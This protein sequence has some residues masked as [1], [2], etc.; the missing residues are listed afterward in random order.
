MPHQDRK[1]ERIIVNHRVLKQAIDKLLKAKA[2][3]RIGIRSG[4]KWTP[5]TLVVM[6]LLWAWSE[7][8]TLLERFAE[9]LAVVR[10]IFRWRK[11][12]GKSYQGFLKQLRKWHAELL[13]TCSGQLRMHMRQDPFGRW[14]FAGF[15]L[16]AGDG[17]RVE[18]PRTVSNEEKYSGGGKGKGKRPVGQRKRSGGKGRRRRRKQSA[19]ERWKKAV[20]P[21]IYLTLL[22]HI[23]TGLPW[24]WRT[25][26]VGTDESK[27][28]IGMLE[29]LPENALIV[30]DAHYVGYDFLRAVV[31]SGRE[32]VIRGGANVRLL[33][34][35][36]YVREYDGIFYLWP[37]KAM[38][39]RE[40]P[41][42]MRVVW[43]QAGK[44]R[45]CLMTSVLSRSRLSDKQLAQIYRARW[46]I[47]KC[48]P[49]CVSR[50]L[51]YR[52]A[53]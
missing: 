13:I 3:R 32:F 4:S 8:P 34:A 40:R 43:V 29:E 12:L 26:A 7:A 21:Q 20:C 42:V 23:G 18:L 36:G 2:F 6:A 41:L 22:W 44:E 28:V 1:S 46:G 15:V 39:H 45:M 16:M 51:L 53:G 10:K 11:G 24:C 35:L 31:D 47:E 49:E 9:A 52:L 38:R 30:A 48:Q 25:G 14:E 5:W 33:R 17:S 37:K 50:A 27:Q 19:K